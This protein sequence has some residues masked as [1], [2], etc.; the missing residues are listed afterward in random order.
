VRATRKLNPAE[1][2]L[3]TLGAPDLESRV[4]EAMP[5]L[6]VNYPNLDWEWL[7][8]AAKQHDLQNRLGFVVT[9][10]REL[11]ESRGMRS[12][13]QVLRHWETILERSRLHREEAFAIATAKT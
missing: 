12:A 7:V 1:L 6:L 9:V 10:A 13:S 5:W 3:R 4:V 11:A 2:L 8:L